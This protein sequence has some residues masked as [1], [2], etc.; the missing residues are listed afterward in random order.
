[1]TRKAVIRHH[2]LTVANQSYSL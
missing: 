2:I 1:M